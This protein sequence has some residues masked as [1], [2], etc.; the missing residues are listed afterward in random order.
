M[1]SAPSPQ[2]TRDPLRSPPVSTC[3][4]RRGFENESI[5]H[6]RVDLSQIFNSLLV[7]SDLGTDDVAHAA[8]AASLSITSERFAMNARGTISQIF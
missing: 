2:W 5:H 1:K 6:A 7:V 8:A 3:S 4:I